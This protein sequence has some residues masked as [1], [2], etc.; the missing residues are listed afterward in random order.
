MSTRGTRVPAK[1]YTVHQVR[2]DAVSGVDARGQAV[3]HLQLQVLRLQLGARPQ[4]AGPPG[5]PHLRQVTSVT[6]PDLLTSPAQGLRPSGGDQLG[7][8]RGLAEQEDGALLIHRRAQRP[9]V[10]PGDLL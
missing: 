4:P 3:L 2:H 5:H 1:H 6:S 7:Q 9:A 10:L 8:G